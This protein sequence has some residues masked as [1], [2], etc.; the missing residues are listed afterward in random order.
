MLGD[1]ID[2]LD[3][4]QFRNPDILSNIYVASFGSYYTILIFKVSIVIADGPLC[5]CDTK[6]LQPS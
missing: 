2:Q 5:I 1:Q 6:H 3:T 4:N